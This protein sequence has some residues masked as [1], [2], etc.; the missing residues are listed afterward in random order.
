MSFLV[1]ALAVN[2]KFAAA[3]SVRAIFHNEIRRT[4]SQPPFF[5]KTVIGTDQS[6]TSATFSSGKVG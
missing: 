1:K 2:D 6:S 3:A 4:A 5:N